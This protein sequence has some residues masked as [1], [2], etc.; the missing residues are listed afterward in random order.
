M[1]SKPVTTKDELPEGTT[2]AEIDNI[3]AEA[4]KDGATSCEVVTENDKRFIVITY[5]PV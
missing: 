5:P 2:Q 1:P 3:C 4:E